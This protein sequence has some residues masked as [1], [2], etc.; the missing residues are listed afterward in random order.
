VEYS[1]YL[2][3]LFF[4]GHSTKYAYVGAGKDLLFEGDPAPTDCFEELVSIKSENAIGSTGKQRIVPWLHK[5]VARHDDYI[6]VLT[7]PRMQSLELRESVKILLLELPKDI[8]S[9]LIVINADSPAE[10]RRWL[11]K[12]GFSSPTN[13]DIQQPTLEVYSDE[14]MEW[15]R[16]YTALGDKRWSLSMFVLAAERIQK[17]AREVDQY[18]ASR[19]IQNA[20]KAHLEDTRVTIRNRKLE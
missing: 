4:L 20:V 2:R 17:L 18:G 6:V 15:M 12:S 10:N 9:R 5:N 19:T 16:S 3:F 7:D 14:K 1:F 8:Q 13:D 11:K